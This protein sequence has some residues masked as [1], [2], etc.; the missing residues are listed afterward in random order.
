ML[1]LGW[2]LGRW[3]GIDPLQ[4]LHL[5][6]GAIILGVAATVPLLLGLR[7]TLITP[8]PPVRRLVQQVQDQLGPVLASRSSGDLALLALLAGSAEEVLFRGV[9]QGGLARWVP[10]VLA[11]MVASGVF[12]LAHFLTLSYAMLAG[13]AGAYLGMLYLVEGN[14]L[15]PVVAHALYDFVALTYLVRR[16]RAAAAGVGHA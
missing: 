8:W 15:V 13:V 3:L 7:W 11:V 5:S 9:I 14:L 10:D 16:Y 6:A 2:A 4:T 1:L 12:G